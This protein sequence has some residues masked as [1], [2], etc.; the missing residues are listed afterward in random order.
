MAI[1]VDSSTEHRLEAAE[2]LVGKPPQSRT[3]FSWETF[4]T[5]LLLSIG[6]VI[7]V[8]PFVWMILT[9][10]KPATELVQ[11]SFLPV[12]PTLDNYV[13]VL[14]TNSFGQWYFNSILIA[15][16]ST[17]SVAFFDTLVGYTLNKFEFPGKTIIFLGILATL[18]IPTEML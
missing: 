18:M 9:S 7:M 5:Y 8:T 17:T 14:G 13:E 15:L 12:N 16:I 4:L 10:L 1:S 11:F 3:R 6:A 2:R